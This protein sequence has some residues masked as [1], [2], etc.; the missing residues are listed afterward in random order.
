MKQGNHLSAYEGA[1]EFQEIGKKNSLIH[2][3]YREFKL[4]HSRRTMRSQK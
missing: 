2:T 1:R 3:E 4:V